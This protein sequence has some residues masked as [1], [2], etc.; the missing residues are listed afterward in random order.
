MSV[1]LRKVFFSQLGE[2]RFEPSAKRIRAMVGDETVIDTTRAALLWEP[3]RIVP[4]YAVPAADIRAEL[5]PSTPP[6]VDSEADGIQGLAMPDVSDRPVLDPSIPFDVHTADGQPM[7]VLTSGS[8]PKALPGAGF[9]LDDHDLEG[10]VVLDFDAFTWYEENEL[11]VAH[12]KDPFHRIDILS[13][14]RHVRLELNGEL[15]AESTRP[16]MLF[17]TSLPVRF[18]LPREDVRAQLTATQT[19]TH[20]AYKGQASY[21]SVQAAGDTVPDIAWTYLKPLREAEPIRDHVA[22]FDESVDVVLDGVARDRP[23]TPWSTRR[24][25]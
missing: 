25:G 12:P 4:T 16:L 18:Y 7:D 5:V 2:V 8:D 11:N 3:R 9:R 23:V 13:S 1:Q 24:S 17:E 22:F 20:C 6:P 19:H 10:Y 21:W 15:L 14:S